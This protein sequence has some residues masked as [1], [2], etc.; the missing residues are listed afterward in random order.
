MII[1]F[2][3]LVS[4]R[5]SNVS[6]FKQKTLNVT[7]NVVATNGY[8]LVNGGCNFMKR[9]KLDYHILEDIDI[10]MFEHLNDDT[11]EMFE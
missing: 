2:T 4:F 7:M 9:A 1:I 8:C 5:V 3:F 10:F 6:L 11:N